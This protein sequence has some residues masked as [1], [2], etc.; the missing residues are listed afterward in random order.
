M[1]NKIISA[2]EAAAVFSTVDSLLQEAEKSRAGNSRLL[3]PRNIHSGDPVAARFNK[4]RRQA[5]SL[6][7]LFDQ[8]KKISLSPEAKSPNY[9]PAAGQESFAKKY[10]FNNELLAGAKVTLASAGVLRTADIPQFLLQTGVS[11]EHS[12]FAKLKQFVENIILDRVID[13][14]HWLSAK[15]TF[16]LL[17]LL[18]K[19]TNKHSIPFDLAAA[20]R[21]EAFYFF[22]TI[23]DILI[24]N[25]TNLAEVTLENYAGRGRQATAVFKISFHDKE[26]RIYEKLLAL[27][28]IIGRIASPGCKINIYCPDNDKAALLN[29]VNFYVSFSGSAEAGISY[30]EA[31][32]TIEN[33]YVYVQK[34]IAELD[35]EKNSPSEA[36]FQEITPLL[37]K[38]LTYLN[39][40]SEIET[41][42]FP[43][44]GIVLSLAGREIILPFVLGPKPSR[45]VF[46]LHGEYQHGWENLKVRDGFQRALQAAGAPEPDFSIALD[47]Q[48]LSP[49]E[50]NYFRRINLTPLA[51]MYRL[52]AADHAVRLIER[53]NS[54]VTKADFIEKIIELLYVNYNFLAEFEKNLFEDRL[55]LAAHNTSATDKVKIVC[56]NTLKKLADSGKIS[57]RN[58]KSWLT[59]AVSYRELELYAAEL[60]K[61]LKTFQKHRQS[62]NMIEFLTELLLKFLPLTQKIKSNSRPVKMLNKLW[63]LE[64]QFLKEHNLSKTERLLAK[65]TAVLTDLQQGFHKEANFSEEVF[66]KPLWDKAPSGNPL[67]ARLRPFFIDLKNIARNIYQRR[68]D[69]WDLFIQFMHELDACRNQRLKYENL[70]PARELLASF[71]GQADY[72]ALLPLINQEMRNE[73]KKFLSS[74]GAQY[75][76]EQAWYYQDNGS[77][78]A[79]TI[80]SILAYASSSGITLSALAGDMHKELA[81][82]AGSIPGLSKTSIENKLLRCSNP[83]SGVS[84]NA[85]IEKILIAL[86]KKRTQNLYCAYEIGL[87]CDSPAV[88][89]KAIYNLI[90]RVGSESAI[91]MIE[92]TAAKFHDHKKVNN[93]AVGSLL[94]P[95][96]ELCAVNLLEFNEKGKNYALIGTLDILLWSMGALACIPQIADGTPAA[97]IQSY[98]YIEQGQKWEELKKAKDSL[99]NLLAN[100]VYAPAEYEQK[101]RTLREQLISVYLGFTFPKGRSGL[102]RNILRGSADIY[103]YLTS[104][105][106][107]AEASQKLKNSLLNY[108][109]DSTVNFPQIIQTPQAAQAL[110]A[111][112]EYALQEPLFVE[113]VGLVQKISSGKNIDYLVYGEYVDN[114]T[115]KKYLGQ[116]LLRDSNPTLNSQGKKLRETSRSIKHFAKALEQKLLK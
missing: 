74:G 66:Y 68:T 62:Y 14:A 4:D 77:A 55:V 72:P 84:L 31:I 52:P 13:L 58:Y 50:Q 116:R 71:W 47:Y 91:K 33:Y 82:V 69:D 10:Y 70:I 60:L 11:A 23:Q 53:I 1:L 81:A 113:N 76:F 25:F 97:R 15:N 73:I 39:S 64:K 90:K 89:G 85:G 79:F 59:C 27:L 30:A 83:D 29:N 3:K 80:G 54:P 36:D 2:G 7:D 98:L 96:N 42:Y 24:G 108:H 92:G 93:I 19:S 26:L 106:L 63:R 94:S 38:A 95:E 67:I 110:A 114:S 35:A 48:R 103:D 111:P 115:G 49:A 105:Q 112:E 46:G 88:T 32:K 65:L 102:A 109:T 107:L 104:S 34:L 37:R 101:S 22:S 78:S 99:Q 21:Q 8:L 41:A 17:T 75:G 5:L 20:S 43:G 18:I 12:Y 9:L 61:E 45:R 57:A 40:A 87:C 28:L 86:V 51:E 100:P 6:N 44:V 56:Q 16:L